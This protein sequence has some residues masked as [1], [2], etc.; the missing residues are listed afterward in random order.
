M[1]VNDH[2]S[3]SDEQELF[4]RSVPRSERRL[5]GAAYAKTG[6][7]ACTEQMCRDDASA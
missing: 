5:G 3:E 6:R 4:A 1:Q 7:G 2:T